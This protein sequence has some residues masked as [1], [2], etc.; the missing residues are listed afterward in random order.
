MEATSPTIRAWRRRKDIF[1]KDQ[2]V[3]YQ[4]MTEVIV[5]Q[6][7]ASPGSANDLTKSPLSLDVNRMFGKEN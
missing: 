7:L 5:E 2:S 1:T 3:T 4:L 6:P